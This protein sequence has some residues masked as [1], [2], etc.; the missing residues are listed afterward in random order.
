MHKTTVGCAALLVLVVLTVT[1]APPWALG[2]VP[3]VVPGAPQ[4]G[5]ADE[6]VTLPDTLTRDEVRDLVSRL[7]DREVR[8]LLISQLDKVAAATEA[9]AA[10]A[11]PSLDTL[12]VEAQ[13]RLQTAIDAAPDFLDLGDAV[14]DRLSDGGTSWFGV[15]LGLLLIFGTGLAAEA[16]FRRLF[17]QFQDLPASGRKAPAIDKLCLLGVRL[18]RDLLALTVFG[19]VTTA[20]FF[21][22]WQG[23]EAVREAISDL[24][25]FIIVVRVAAAVSRFVLAPGELREMRLPGF[26][27]PVA[28]GLHLRILI[29]IA[30]IALAHNVSSF[31]DSLQMTRPGLIIVF[32]SFVASLT[33]GVI[34]AIVWHDRRLVRDWLLASDEDEAATPGRLRL[35]VARNWHILVTAFLVLLFFLHLGQRLLT[36]QSAAEPILISL[37]LLF[38][39]PALDLMMQSAL[40]SMLGLREA[41]ANVDATLAREAAARAALDSEPA[42]PEDTDPDIIAARRARLSDGLTEAVAARREAQRTDQARRDYRAVLLQS[43]RIVLAV[44]FV[45]V[46]ARIWD[47]NLQAVATRSVG[48]TVAGSA[49]DI[50]AV[51]LIA[52]AIWGMVKAAIRNALPPE[53]DDDVGES[54]VG[55]KGGTRLQTLVPLF[56]RFLLV[57]I[58]VMVA[59]IILSELGVDIGPLIAGAGI[60][61]IAIGFGAQTL[62]RDIL[63]GVFFLIDDA[64]RVGEYID[65]GSVRGMVEHISIRSLRLRHHLGPVHTI[66]FGEI[67]HLTNFSRDWAIMK[68]E[69]R[70]P[71]DTDLEKVRKIV[72]KVG[73]ELM[74]HPEHG[75]SFLQPVKSQ[76]VHRMDDDAFI[77]RVK[78]MARPGEQFVLRREVYRRIQEAFCENGIHFAPRRVIVDTTGQAAPPAALAAAA[79]A[80]ALDADKSGEGPEEGGHSGAFDL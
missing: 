23:N 60:I 2:A 42:A 67:A 77:I 48:E 12:L 52:S 70:V 13:W 31:V 58:A 50:I 56:G 1:V 66:P 44:I 28:R 61:G 78:F 75:K 45:F 16:L 15:L 21:I 18:I 36:G 53:R 49:L 14:G 17:P 69:L 33:L 6:P 43:L 62:V 65:V 68:L 34:I 7:S 39:L 54:E 24:F 5:P 51:L 20:M 25:W 55:G 72:K 4:A 32:G 76:G 71:F 79:A 30:T 74:A 38:A 29:I 26:S 10:P 64:F 46:L 19:M 73:Q 40:R 27:D 80:G 63:S 3:G 37:A 22:F 9:A 35:F 41:A 57:V 59:M 11:G 8:D 47:L